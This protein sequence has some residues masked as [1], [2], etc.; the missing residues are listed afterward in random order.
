MD[1]R[2]H[3]GCG[4]NSRNA[5]IVEGAIIE[6]MIVNKYPDTTV[7]D[8]Q[9]VARGLVSHKE[10]VDYILDRAALGYESGG[11]IVHDLYSADDA[12]RLE[13]RQVADQV[14]QCITN[15]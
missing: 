7:M 2:R 10:Q 6:G 15:A 5:R 12:I 3:G 13:A 4:T 9:E 11:E 1:V 14:L 8:D